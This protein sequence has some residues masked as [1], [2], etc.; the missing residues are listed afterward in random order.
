M[1]KIV[2]RRIL[3]YLFNRWLILPWLPI[4]TYVLT[5][6]FARNPSWAEKIYSRNIYHFVANLLSNISG[7]FPFSI[8]D[9]FYILLIS[10]VF[11]LI[12]LLVFRKITFKYTGKIVLNILSTVYILFYV[13]WGF[14][15]F[16]NGINQ[17][18]GLAEREPNTEQFILVLKDLI[19]KTNTSYSSFYDFDEYKIDRLIEES[20]NNLSQV[21]QYDYPAGK[22]KAKSITFSRFFAK[23]G[24]SGYYGPFFNEVH[25]NK[26]NLPIEYP[27]V[28]THEKAH[29]LGITSEAEANFYAWLIC[30][31]SESKQLQYSAN[32]YVLKFFMYQGYQMEQYPEIIK[33][34][35]ENVKIDF[36]RIQEHWINLRNEKVD[37][38]ASKVNDTYLKTNKIEKGI[39]DYFGVVKHVMDFSLD[40]V[41]QKKWDLVH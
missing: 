6:I 23:A 11:I 33:K 16:R 40:S 12:V 18:I 29:Q 27:F 14:N 35:D 37:K 32:L 26:N 38:V 15:Y 13:L 24:I 17:R 9:I 8:D 36:R 3:K 19:E 30:S 5:E 41:F 31:Q 10:T 7:L 28:L 2:Q 22:R 1:K 25:I 39:E 34:L 20:Y 4:A 21:L